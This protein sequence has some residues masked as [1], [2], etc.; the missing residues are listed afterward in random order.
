MEA[1]GEWTLNDIRGATPLV[2][3]TGGRWRLGTTVGTDA[4]F[5]VSMWHH[6]EYYVAEHWLATSC[7]GV[8]LAN[9][10]HYT[11]SGGHEHG[12]QLGP[13]P[14]KVNP[15]PR[16]KGAPT[17]RVHLDRYVHASMDNLRIRP[18]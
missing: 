15:G 11:A 8:L 18:L 17:L 16:R 5:A 3:S 1:H 7:D 9:V 10:T 12:R 2:L 13:Q 14:G 6:V 4:P